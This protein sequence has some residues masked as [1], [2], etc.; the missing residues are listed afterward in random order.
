MQGNK[1]NK[2]FI[3]F[4]PEY[5]R[6][7]PDLNVYAIYPDNWGQ[8]IKYKGVHNWGEPPVLGYVK[9]QSPYW[10]K[11]AAYVAGIVYPNATFEPKPVAIKF[12]GTQVPHSNY[13]KKFNRHGNSTP[14]NKV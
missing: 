8:N 2:Q 10:A 3:I 6:G 4:T 12:K 14:G 5:V 13:K 7:M 9:E 11:I 1:R